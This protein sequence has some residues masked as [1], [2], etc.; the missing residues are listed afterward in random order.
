VD[1]V[2]ERSVV[3]L[4]NDYDVLFDL[5]DVIAAGIAESDRP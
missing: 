3:A 5:L 4:L 2:A 1:S